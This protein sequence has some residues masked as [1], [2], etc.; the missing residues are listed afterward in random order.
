MND[1]EVHM[2]ANHIS[3]NFKYSLKGKM[4]EQVKRHL[5]F[6]IYAK[7]VLDFLEEIGIFFD[8]LSLA[9]I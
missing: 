7:T 4:K 3:E 1:I 9:N 6:S 8:T 2:S 5:P